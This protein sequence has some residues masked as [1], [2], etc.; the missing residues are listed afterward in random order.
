MFI[1]LHEGHINVVK[2]FAS[3]VDWYQMNQQMIGQHQFSL[4]HSKDTLT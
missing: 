1:A 4:H 3:K 2:F